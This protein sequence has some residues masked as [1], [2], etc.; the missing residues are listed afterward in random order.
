[1]K[2]VIFSG[3][4]VC[5]SALLQKFSTDFGDFWRDG[6]V[7]QGPSGYIMTVMRKTIWIQQLLKDVYT[8]VQ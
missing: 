4:S 3:L 6:G 7:A 5:L 2:E 8:V 1:M